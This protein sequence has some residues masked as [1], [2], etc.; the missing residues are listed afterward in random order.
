MLSEKKPTPS[1]ILMPFCFETTPS[2]H[3]I[4][5]SYSPQKTKILRVSSGNLFLFLPLPLCWGNELSL[6]KY[7]TLA[8]CFGTRVSSVNVFS[9]FL[10][11]NRI[12]AKTFKRERKNTFRFVHELFCAYVFSDL[13]LLQRIDVNMDERFSYLL[14]HLHVDVFL[15]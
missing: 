10:S 1:L 7:V 8:F 13:K 12:D 6:G 11:A 5:F 15:V 9:W 4:C 14:R 3:Y 2:H